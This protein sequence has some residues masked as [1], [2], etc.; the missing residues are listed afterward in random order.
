MLEEAA[1]RQKKPEVIKLYYFSVYGRAEALR[2][3]LNHAGIEYDDIFIDFQDWGEWKP[4]LNYNPLPLCVFPDGREFNQ[5]QTLMRYFGVKYG[6]YP[7]GDLHKQYECDMICD[8]FYELLKPLAEPVWDKEPMR[9]KGK[10]YK[11]IYEHLIPFIKIIEFK[12]SDQHWLVTKKK[13]TIA[14]FWVGGMYVN[15]IAN[16]K[17]Y[18]RVEFGELLEKYPQLRAYG[19]RFK[20]ENHRYLEI[21]PKRAF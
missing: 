14:D 21:R 16:P 19:E 13:M 17:A 20:Y 12:L 2:L 3:L 4:K 11:M 1:A 6:Y 15:Y 10:I 9:R 8:S 18:G 5:A 7:E